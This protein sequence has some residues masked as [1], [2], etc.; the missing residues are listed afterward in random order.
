[1]NFHDGVRA[2]KPISTAAQSHLLCD[3][4]R[5]ATPYLNDYCIFLI[6][7]SLSS[8]RDRSVADCFLFVLF[9]R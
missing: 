3:F 2:E 1:M 5:K 6:V 9:W 4:S 8:I 7:C